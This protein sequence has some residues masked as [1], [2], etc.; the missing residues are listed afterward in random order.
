MSIWEGQQQSTRALAQSTGARLVFT[1][2]VRTI[3]DKVAETGTTATVSTPGYGMEIRGDAHEYE[4]LGLSLVESNPVTITWVP[5][6]GADVPKVGAIATWSGVSRT[7]RSVAP[8][9]A[10]DGLCL[11]AR[12]IMSV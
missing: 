4:Q 9:R 8:K 11:C 3:V 1:R 2:S 12:V 7:I 6:A 10:P 5:D